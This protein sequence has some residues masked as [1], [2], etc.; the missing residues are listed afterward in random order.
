MFDFLV[1]F[2]AILKCIFPLQIQY[3]S[4]KKFLAIAQAVPEFV[5]DDIDVYWITKKLYHLT[6]KYEE[7]IQVMVN[8]YR[9]L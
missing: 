5:D 6:E 4:S 9:F 2:R 3:E 1:L 8:A 7:F